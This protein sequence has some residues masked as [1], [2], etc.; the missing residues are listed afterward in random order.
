MPDRPY[1]KWYILNVW[2]K[3]DR[4]A[5]HNILSPTKEAS[6]ASQCIFDYLTKPP[7]RRKFSLCRSVLVEENYFDQDFIDSIS[8]FYSKGFRN[9]DRLCTRLHFFSSRIQS[10]DITG[11]KLLEKQQDYYLGFAV[12]RPLETKELGRSAIKPRREEPG[13]EFHTCRMHSPVNIAGSAL[14]VEAAPY[15]EQDSRVQTCSSVAIWISSTVMAYCLDYPKYTTS[16]IMDYATRNIVGARAGPTQ[17][18]TYE[19]IMQAL[20][21]MGYEPVIFDETDPFEA[22]YEIYCYVES[23][24]PPILL[25]ELPDSNYHAITALGHAHKRPLEST[26]QITIERLGRTILKYCRSSEW[27]PYFYIHD[28]QRGIYRELRFL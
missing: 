19:Q 2:Q 13:I 25:L 24:T 23:E 16:Q 22:I 10:S 18:L 5:L 27:V 7:K 28:D 3:R 17:G 21:I 20:K 1:D 11:F 26:L 12:V 15:M 4:E 6:V 14:F 9:I 8:T